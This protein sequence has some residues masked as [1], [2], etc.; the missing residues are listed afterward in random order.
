MITVDGVE[1]RVK[2]CDCHGQHTDSRS[3][4]Q[5]TNLFRNFANQ[6][7]SGRLNPDWPM[8][9]LKTQQV[10]DACYVSANNGGLVV[11]VR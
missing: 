8:M 4:A 10:M 6:V 11:T 5:D 3:M 7:R 9:A 2:V 1:E